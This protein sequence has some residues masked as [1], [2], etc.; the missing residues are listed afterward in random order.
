M[1]QSGYPNMQSH[2]CQG[3]ISGIGLFWWRSELTHE[4][5]L[6]PQ[7]PSRINTPGTADDGHQAQGTSLR[8]CPSSDKDTQEL[9]FPAKWNPSPPRAELCW[10]SHWWR[11]GRGAEDKNLCRALTG[12]EP[13]LSH[14]TSPTTNTDP[15]CLGK[16]REKTLTF[17]KFKI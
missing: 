13:S 17:G 16:S 15:H 7:P 4:G 8:S 10:A 11:L 6:T 9:L 1:V 5:P 3:S 2:I 14:T 12:A